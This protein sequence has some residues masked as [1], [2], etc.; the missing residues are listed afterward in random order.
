MA[1]R[2]GPIENLKQALTAGATKNKVVELELYPQA[3]RDLL[4]ALTALQP[5]THNG[6]GVNHG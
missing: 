3:C 4:D 6:E 5:K 2:G 1:N